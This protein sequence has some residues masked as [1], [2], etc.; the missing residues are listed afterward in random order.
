MPQSTSPLPLKKRIVIQSY[1]PEGPL[2]HMQNLNE[3]E[4]RFSE[5]D[6]L[7]PV[8]S[9]SALSLNNDIFDVN[10]DGT[11]IFVNGSNEL[12][13]IFPAPPVIP[14]VSNFR[15][16][17]F[18][19]SQ[20]LANDT[21]T[22]SFTTWGGGI[23][24]SGFAGESIEVWAWVVGDIQIGLTGTGGV[25]ETRLGISLNGG[26]SFTYGGSA[27]GGV[28]QVSTA[29]ALQAIPTS[30]LHY[31]AGTVASSMQIRAE[32]RTDRTPGVNLWADGII[33]YLITES[34]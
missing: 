31:R 20:G 32:I 29:D 2:E 14:D 11:S 3:I 4:R 17:P 1:Q 21:A 30:T 10:V 33:S 24:I 23:T 12:E 26:G 25:D 28:P 22:G 16:P 6:L 5:L 15:P 13:V 27:T 19:G 7:N 34:L 8:D 18:G 9:G